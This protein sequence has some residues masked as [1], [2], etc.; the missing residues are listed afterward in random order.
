MVS[1]PTTVCLIPGFFGFAN[2][3][4]HRYFEHVRT[5]LGEALGRQGVDARLLDLRVRPTA[6]L[7]SRA[8]GVAR[9]V[10]AQAPTGPIVLLG[11]STG[12]LDA[13]LLVAPGA[14]LGGDFDV[15]PVARRVSAVVTVCTPHRGTPLAYAFASPAGKQL[16]QLLSLITIHVVRDAKLPPT[17]VRRLAETLVQLDRGVASSGPTLDQIFR[18]LLH[19]LEPDR[20]QALEEYFDGVSEEQALLPQL[21][22]EAL[23]LLDSTLHDR[24][25][26]RTGC[27]VCRARPPRL[28]GMA[29]LGFDPYAQ[30]MYA[31]YRWLHGRATAYRAPARLRWTPDE[32]EALLAAFG[33]EPASSDSDGI[34][35]VASQVWGDVIHTARA[36]HFDVLGYFDD[37]DRGSAHNDWLPS[38]SRFDRVRFGRLW[39][40]VARFLST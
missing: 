18:T 34:V 35:P 3:G 7:R 21:V 28:A 24:A 17:V 1:E 30:S 40:D 12:G 19:S 31:L 8:L 9:A 13:R 33:E 5:A 29:S 32:R 11:H 22:P 2:L 6:S 36:D 20:R 25:E 26:V 23:E 38:A 15:E 10:E 4:E 27:V 16:L 14:D 37:P 39:S